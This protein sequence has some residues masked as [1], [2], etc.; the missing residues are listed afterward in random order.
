[1]KHKYSWLS[2]FTLA[3]TITSQLESMAATNGPIIITTR[4]GQDLTWGTGDSALK[5]GPGQTSPG[6]V[7]MAALLGDHGYVTRFIIDAER[8][9]TQVNPFSGLPGAQ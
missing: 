3:V 7:A 5:T 1:M 4:K 9:P 8:N 2:A 6:D